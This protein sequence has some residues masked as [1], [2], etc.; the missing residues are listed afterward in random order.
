MTRTTCKRT[1]GT[2]YTQTREQQESQESHILENNKNHENQAYEGNKKHAHT[3]TKTTHTHYRTTRTIRTRV[4]STQL[5]TT[6]RSIL[7]PSRVGPNYSKKS[8][9]LLQNLKKIT[10][11]PSTDAITNSLDLK[12][13]KISKN[14]KKT[15][16][17]LE[18]FSL[19][20]LTFNT[21]CGPLLYKHLLSL[22]L[23]PE[24]KTKKTIHMR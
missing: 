3:R 6:G 8:K 22:P 12:W 5:R 2:T 11:H 15:T 19:T 24:K 14:F 21:S 18:I 23:H 4:I 9:L 13:K 16:L 20:L 17:T 1:A 7:S 10:F